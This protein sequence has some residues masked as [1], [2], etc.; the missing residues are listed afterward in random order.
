M[1]A[2]MAAVGICAVQVLW[3][4]DFLAEL[5]GL[6]MTGLT[7]YMFDEQ[8][9]L[10][11][12]FLSF[13]HFW[14]PIL[15]I[16]LIWKLGYDRRGLAGWTIIAWLA[17]A[18]SYLFLPGPGDSL[19]FTNQPCNVNYVYGLGTE[20]QTMMPEITW[21]GTIMLGLPTIIYV[22]SHFIFRKMFAAP[23]FHSNPV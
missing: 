18:V 16:Y 12:R 1:L 15:I 8:I 13:F 22:P 4:V 17:M 19:A 7:S 20:A 6:K 21:L 14:L 5:S 9:P 10:F 23:K 3:Q 2:S 11:A